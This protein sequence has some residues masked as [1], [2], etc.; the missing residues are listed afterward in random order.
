M[1]K[2]IL[3]TAIATSLFGGSITLAADTA[4][5]ATVVAAA[6]ATANAPISIDEAGFNAFIEKHKA[7][8][9]VIENLEKSPIFEKAQWQVV[10]QNGTMIRSQLH[11][12]LI[13]EDLLTLPLNSEL[14]T[15]AVSFNGKDFD[16]GKVV[17]RLDLSNAG[18]L[19][20]GITKDTLVVTDYLSSNGD[21]TTAIDIQPINIVDSNENIDFKGGKAIIDASLNH[22]AANFELDLKNFSATNNGKYGDALRISPVKM[23]M[24][25]DSNGNYQGTS[26]PFTLDV[27]DSRPV[28][29]FEEEAQT[30]GSESNEEKIKTETVNIAVGNG[31]YKG[32]F[33]TVPGLE[34]AIN[35]GASTIDTLTITNDNVPV[36]LNNINFTGGLYDMGQKL[37]ELKV[38]FSTQIDAEALKT[39]GLLKE[40]SIPLTPSYIEFGY[41][42]SKVGYDAVNLY[43]QSISNMTPDQ[44]EL[45]NESERQAFLKSLQASDA[46]LHVNAKFNA[47]EGNGTAKA[48]ISMSEKGKAQT[49]EQLI[50]AFDRGPELLASLLQGTANVRLNRALADSTG[51]TMFLMMGGAKPDGEDYIIDAVLKDGT[52]E[53]NG[54]PIPLEEP[55]Q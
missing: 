49:V 33:K 14:V 39:S 7:T 16:F 24:T 11:L 9:Y 36:K 45:F 28:Y 29:D 8:P 22:T 34:T 30:D 15:G 23:Q 41:G 35:N 5:P 18:D 31:D 55:A 2:L 42:I 37:T 19:P 38:G 10:E 17:T 44:D 52:L 46:A 20:P 40:A 27:V 50:A 13:D 51:A 47:A 4:T 54:M 48:N 1:K 26:A 6:S 32:I 12:K 53:L 43:M 3:S 25:L 21:I